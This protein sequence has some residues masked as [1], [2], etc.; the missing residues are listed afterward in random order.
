V[1]EGIE[2][3]D[4]LALVDELGCEA[5]QGYLI[6]RPVPAGEVALGAVA[7]KRLAV[8]KRGA[9]RARPRT[10]QRISA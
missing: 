10:A 5:A 9:S 3:L 1:A 7:A 2:T 4:D 6:G 8:A